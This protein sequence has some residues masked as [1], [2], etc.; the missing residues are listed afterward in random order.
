MKYL[1][2]VSLIFALIACKGD[3]YLRGEVEPS[4]DGNTYFGVIDNNGG[5][6]GPLLL[7]GKAWELPLGEVSEIESGCNST[8]FSTAIS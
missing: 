4:Q 8:Q 3:G 1:F 5:N 7:D 2:I 6:C